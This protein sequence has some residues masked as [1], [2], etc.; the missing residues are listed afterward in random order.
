MTITLLFSCGNKS[1]DDHGHDSHGGHDDHADHAGGLLLT[2]A[3]FETVGME[4]GELSSIKINDYVKATGTL[5]LPPNAFATVSA[6]AS[7]IISG[8]KKFI[9]GNVIKKGEIIAYI[10]NTDFIE[11][12]QEFL[13][14]KAQLDY[15]KLD[16]DRQR[17]LV[18]SGAGASKELQLLES[19]FAM[20][21]AKLQGLK[22][23][24]SYLGVGTKNLTPTT[25]QQ[26]I[27][28]VA[29][30][31]GYISN[32]N[33]N[34]G[35]YA[36]LAVSLMEIISDDH[37]HL[38]LDVFEKDIAKIQ[39]DQ[40]I[41]YSLPAMGNVIYEGEVS[42][43][44]KEFDME[45]KTV[46][47]HGHLHGDQPMFFKDLYIN[48]KIWLN[49]DDSKAIQESSVVRDGTS[50]YIFIAYDNP[51]AE[52]ITFEKI[53]VIAGASSDGFTSIKLLSEIPNG[54]KVVTN[55]AYYVYAQSRN[56]EMKHEH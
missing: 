48:A 37:L 30:M 13:E 52:E 14:T 29:P 2:R 36:E 35:M 4:L 18:D 54:M 15:K 24:L 31:S 9:E 17:T 12:Q 51:K 11:K 10:E 45:S 7:G 28:I 8:N 53:D 50:T 23:Q 39:I 47:V 55:G 27:P 26:R 20:L 3:Q 1:Q 42:V 38:E 19:E 40:K 44:G 6:K 49:D 46:R 34:N 22:S 21:N 56:G 41:S 5:G 25:M 32:I 43:V 16:L 33:L